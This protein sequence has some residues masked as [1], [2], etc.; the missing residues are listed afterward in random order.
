MHHALTRLENYLIETPPLYLVTIAIVLGDALGNAWCFAAPWFAIVLGALAGATF[1]A[2]RRAAAMALVLAG[3]VAAA[4]IPVHHLLEPPRDVTSLTRFGD[5]STITVEG[6]VVHEPERVEGE[7]DR[8]HLDLW[9][10][11]AAPAPTELAPANGLIRVTADTNFA[12]HVGDELRVTSRIRFPR[13]DGNPGEFDYRA[14]LMRQGIVATMFAEP[15]KSDPEP[16]RIIGHRE[17]I[18][19]SRI[20]TIRERIGSF[21]DANLGYPASAE[22]RAL[23]IGDRGGIGEP[24]RQSFALTGMAHL[25]VISGLHLGIVATTAFL[26]AR[27]LMSFLPALMARGYA[28]KFAAIAAAL[29]VCGYAAI[30]GHHVS[31]IRALVMVLTYAFAILLDRSRELVS[32]L[33]LAALLICLTLPGSTAD[34][35]FQ[36]SFASVFVILMGMRR[37][38]AWWRWRYMNPLAPRT[39]RSRLNSVSEAVAGYI[40]VS[41][42]A[43]MGTAPL[44]AFH[45]NQFS[46]VGLISNAVVVPIMGF[47][48]VVGGLVAAALSFIATTPARGLLWFAG[49]LAMVG[50]YLAGW[51]EGWPLAWERIFTPTPIELGIAYGFILLWLTAPLKGAVVLEQLRRRNATFVAARQV[52][53]SSRVRRAVGVA[54]CAAL[55]LDGAWWTYQRYLNRDLRVTFLSVG[56][57]DA[58]L[59][60]FPGSRVM[61]IDG[62]GA[63]R[64]TFDPGERIVAPLLWSQKIM[65]VDYVAVSHPDHDHFAGLT[66]IARNFTP[67]HFWTSGTDSPDESYA[68][69]LEA[70]KQAGA[71][72]AIC[73]SA[74][75]AM[76]I[77]GVNLRCVGPIAGAAE[78]K[79]NNSSM[80]LRLSYGRH[81]LLFPGDLEAKGE[82]EL[83]A[84][85]ADLRATILKV[86]HHGSHTSSTTELIAAAHPAVAVISLGYHNRF[87]FPADEVLQRYRDAGVTVLR[88]DEDGAI[89]A[90]VG[91]DSIR[92]L[93]FRFG[94]VPVNERR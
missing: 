45:F 14:W 92:L 5:D 3:L 16:I 89:S 27:L 74:S 72:S 4:T 35:G 22:M 55:I 26:I 67:S 28:N 23:I 12:M 64:S 7:R 39:E 76:M 15:R 93:S 20:E 79:E 36:L 13:N 56:E 66:F 75:R 42:W 37:F 71:R 18:F 33:A 44:T 1:L 25:L 54:L 2:S 77:G 78:L 31:T 24:L 91:L 21:I 60:R 63:F 32:S 11:R 69:L 86:P 51:F 94:Q 29:A 10:A 85:G 57:G 46:I 90:D 52:S 48:A 84:S 47:G 80:V 17:F 49:K 87:H 8:I 61:L 40:A 6:Y 82:R 59:V 81:A 73:N 62:G 88:T 34:I 43:L 50:T 38:A 68:Q 70:M 41:F 83:I 19:A 53:R 65:H 58:A 9:A 30:A